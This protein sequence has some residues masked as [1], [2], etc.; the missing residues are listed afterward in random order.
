MSIAQQS[1]LSSSFLA[2]LHDA[3]IPILQSHPQGIKEYDLIKKLLALDAALLPD[4]EFSDT[5]TT[6]R[7]H[8]IL[9][10][11]LYKLRTEL[12]EQKQGILIIELVNIQ[13]LPFQS[14]EENKR[15]SEQD[16]VGEYYLDI[17][18]LD[19]TTAQEVNNMLESFW[20]KFTAFDQREIALKALELSDP[21]DFRTIKTNFKRLTMIHHP[22]RGG[23]KERFQE[24]NAAMSVL[25]RYYL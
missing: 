2:N 22:D 6:F 13:L 24:I 25:T 12:L 7:L 19:K 4:P 8:F 20:Q 3:I 15:L 18:N 17:E 10:H 21:V 11:A 1:K 9:Y 16:K 5:Y 14:N 23:N